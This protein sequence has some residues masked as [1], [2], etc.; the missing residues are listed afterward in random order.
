MDV[1][2]ASRII[3]CLSSSPIIRRSSCF[4][5]KKPMKTV[6]NPKYPE[7]KPLAE[8]IERHFQGSSQI[9]HKKRNEIRVV[10]FAGKKYVVKAFR[11]PNLLNRF[12]YRY[13][14]QSKAQRSYRYSLKIGEQYCPEAIACIEEQK[15]FQLFKSYYISRHFDADFEIRAVLTDR[16]FKNRTLI[17]QKFAEFSYELHEK[18]ILHRDYSPGNILIKQHPENYQFKIVD[19]NRMQFKTLSLTDRLGNFVRLAKDDETMAIIIRQYASCINQPFDEMF[20]IARQLRARYVE[21]RALKNK[22]RGR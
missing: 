6:L 5:A 9:L 8:H 11:K 16:Q 21:K 22:L 17:L 1:F 19:V 12:V 13:F 20:A 4:L 3:N 14:R 18:G 7:L 2:T 15:Y 10:T